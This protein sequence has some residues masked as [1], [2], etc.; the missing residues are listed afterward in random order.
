[1]WLINFKLIKMGKT[2]SKNCRVTNSLLMKWIKKT[3]YINKSMSK[4]ENKIRSY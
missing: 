3:I 1:M 2:F 4:Y